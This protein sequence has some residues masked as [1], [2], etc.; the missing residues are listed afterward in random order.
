LPPTYPML[1]RCWQPRELNSGQ[2]RVNDTDGRLPLKTQLKLT[3]SRTRAVGKFSIAK[4]Y[5]P[6]PDPSRHEDLP[7][8]GRLRYAAYTRKVTRTSLKHNH[9]HPSRVSFWS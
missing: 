5:A 9:R 8:A 6:A 2:Y 1:D 4:T 7:I 3:F